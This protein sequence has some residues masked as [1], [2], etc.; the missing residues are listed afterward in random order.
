MRS[1]AA[2]LLRVLNN[3]AVMVEA[4]GGR[5]IL[6]GRGIGFSKHLGDEIPVSAAA[7]VFYPS[8]SQE[9]RQLADFVVEI[10]FETF[11]VAR[12]VVDHAEATAGVR[13][14]QALLLSI[15]DHLH[16]AIVR[17][18]NGTTIDFPLKWEIAQL[19]PREAELG[20]A[21]VHFARTELGVPIAEDEATAFAMHFVN[22]QFAQADVSQTV[23]MTKLLGAAVDIVT[24]GIGSHATADPMSVAR[25]V[26]HLRYLY[27]RILTDSQIESTPPILVPEI[28]RAHPEVS[29]VADQVRQLIESGGGTLTKAE[30]SYLELHV[31]RLATTVR[32]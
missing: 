22:A 16:F 7:E 1:T 29:I 5:L 24:E 3:N 32:R 2:T 26:T 31:A 20:R 28:H 25:F 14:S 21:T 13:P 17:A 15:A 9:L 12:R 6:L 18:E 11:N 19:Y 10:P 30:V 8:S 27:V 4:V 23:E